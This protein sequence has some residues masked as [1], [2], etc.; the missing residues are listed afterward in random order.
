MKKLQ[1]L[2]VGSAI[3]MFAGGVSI[4][5]LSANKEQGREFL[6]E[7]SYDQSCV[8]QEMR[9]IRGVSMSETFDDGEVVSS[10]A[11]YFECNKPESGQIVILVFS[12]RN[13]SFVKKIVA[14]GW[15][16]LEF[17]EGQ[18]KLNGEVLRNPA[19]AA[20]QFS[21]RSQHILSQALYEGR[22]PDGHL[23][24]LSDDPGPSGFDSRQYGFVDADHLKGLVLVP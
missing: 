1:L 18:A 4:M 12:S 8:T 11:G 24:V 6:Q 13:E 15:D 5:F 23:L 3:C 19:G 7:I 9:T 10:L 17:T 22:I 16:T 14:T 20:Y 2:L 21:S